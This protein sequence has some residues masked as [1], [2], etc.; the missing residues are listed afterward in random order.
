MSTEATIQTAS[1]PAVVLKRF[2]R[3]HLVATLYL[4]DCLEM[5]PIMAHAVISDPPY[6]MNWDTDS[7]RFSGGQSSSIKRKPRGE[8][9]GHQSQYG[10]YG[11]IDGDCKPFD[12]APWI[13]YPRCVLFGANHY[14][15]RLPVGTTLVW[16][17]KGQHLWGTFL[18]DAELGWM[19][20]G[21]GVYAFLKSFPP[22]VRAVD[23]GGDP[24]RPVGI[25]PTQKPVALM[26]WCMER[27]KV[28]AGATVL[29]PYMGSGTTGIACLR[30]GR[31]FI[32]IEKDPKH[33]AT[34]VARLEREV[35]QGALL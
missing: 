25:H 6:G 34:A 3:G 17:K 19:K 32:G 22:P 5:L 15:Q 13:E 8:G 35:N 2:V 26:S 24:C 33:F 7:T 27:A 31:N 9:R 18:S 11:K 16:L 20:G 10:D 1:D 4:G 14:A 28:P 30:T 23:A 21:C 29:D 12:P